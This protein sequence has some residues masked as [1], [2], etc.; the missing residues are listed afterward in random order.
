[1]SVFS[2]PK[3][4][5]NQKQLKR[6]QFLFSRER[7]G[8]KTAGDKRGE[9]LGRGFPVLRLTFGCYSVSQG[10]E[11]RAKEFGRVVELTMGNTREHFIPRVLRQY[12]PTYSR[13]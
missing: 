4:C 7:L 9:G 13:V 6:I 2:I 11:E 10:G 1:M 12:I 3:F 8:A 5:K